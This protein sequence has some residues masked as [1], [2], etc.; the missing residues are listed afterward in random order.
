MIQ[1]WKRFLFDRAA[2]WTLPK[3]REW[4]Y[5]LYNNYHPHISSMSLFWFYNNENHP[6]VVTKMFHDPEI[7]TREFANLQQVYASVPTLAPKPLHLGEVGG[8]WTLWMTGLPGVHLGRAGACSFSVQKEIAGMVAELHCAV[9]HLA[10]SSAPDRWRRAIVEPIEA[11]AGY[12]DSVIVREGCRRLMAKI[13]PEWLSGVR[14]IPQHGDLYFG[15]LLSDKSRWHIVDWE[16]YG[17]IDLPFYD[18]CTLLLSMFWESGNT[19]NRWDRKLIEQVPALMRSYALTVGISPGEI[20][21]LL[22]LT[23]VNWFHLQWADGRKDFSARM[24]EALGHYFE[25]ENV[26]ERIFIPE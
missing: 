14:R 6:R 18:L 13:T 20:S 26:W 21:V 25:H 7:P 4:N 22:P 2:E 16:S 8:L 12:G 17:V 9:S 23:L 5:I 19:P 3:S 1:E 11:V 10:G 15:H 24:Y